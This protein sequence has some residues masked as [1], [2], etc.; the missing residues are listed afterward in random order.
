VERRDVAGRDAWT[1]EGLVQASLKRTLF[2]FRGGQLV[3]VELQ[4]QN[5]DWDTYK[6]DDFMSQVRQ[7]IEQKYGA[8][9]VLA[10]SKTPEGDVVQTIVGYKWTQNSTAIELIYF[11]AENA[12]QIYRTISVHYKAY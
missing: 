6:Y 11:C 9:Q 3:E 5:A 7:R 4:Y 1:V 8:G 12:S 10:R 2:Y